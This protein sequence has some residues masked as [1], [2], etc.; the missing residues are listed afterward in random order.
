IETLTRHFLQ[1]LHAP[2]EA[3]ARELAQ[4]EIA[5]ST[6]LCESFNTETWITVKRTPKTDGEGFDEH[7]QV[8]KRLMIGEHKL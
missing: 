2:S 3:A 8:F 4:E 5:Y 6:D 7:Y 1:D